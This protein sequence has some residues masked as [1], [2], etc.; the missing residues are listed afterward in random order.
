M[1]SARNRFF[2]FSYF[3]NS[4]DGQSGMRLAVSDD[5][6][7]YRPINDG[8]P[9]L[10]PGVGESRLMRDPFLLKDPHRDLYHLVWTTSWKGTTIGYASSPDLVNWSEQQALPVMANVSGTRNCWAPEI[11]Y[12]ERAGHFVVF[13]S[14]TVADQA[15]EENIRDHRIYFV[16]TSDFVTF[17]EPAMLFDPGFNVIDASFLR[18]GGKLVLFVKDERHVPEM[19]NI[20][21]LEADSPTGPFGPISAPI[22]GNW[23][24]GPT[25]I[26]LDGETIVFFD[27][28]Q[29]GKY[30]AVATRDFQNWSDATSRISIPNGASHGSIISINRFTYLHLNTLTE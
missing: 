24:E 16:T 12:H 21:W 30:G 18:I 5:G 17:S 25:A 28:Y 3:T 11:V 1:S 4:D 15:P 19:K 9:L 27:Q 14:S 20:F 13:W 7:N 22:T 26:A 29:L 2:L 10:Q 8:K 23:V 6:L